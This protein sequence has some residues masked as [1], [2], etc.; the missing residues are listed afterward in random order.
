MVGAVKI[1]RNVEELT[2]KTCPLSGPRASDRRVE[3]FYKG[4]ML[5]RRTFDKP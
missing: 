2:E 1:G 5:Y 3:R 4:E